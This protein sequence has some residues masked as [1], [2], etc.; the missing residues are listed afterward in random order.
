M[1][2]QYFWSKKLTFFL[3]YR[4]I[5][6][7]I[8]WGLALLRGAWLAFCIFYKF[9]I[10]QYLCY[11]KIKKSATQRISWLKV[12]VCVCFNPSFKLIHWANIPAQMKGQDKPRRFNRLPGQ[13]VQAQLAAPPQAWYPMQLLL[14]ATVNYATALKLWMICHTCQQ[15]TVNQGSDQGSPDLRPLVLMLATPGCDLIKRVAWVQ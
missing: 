1:H 6:G 9:A 8:I 11:Q 13:R 14:P 4:F 3:F 5:P 12:C 10:K 15:K 2:E 7:G